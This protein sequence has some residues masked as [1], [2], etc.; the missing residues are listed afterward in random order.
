LLVSHIYAE[1]KR[2]LL[3]L[4]S[5]ERFSVSVTE[6]LD[7]PHFPRPRQKPHSYQ[8]MLGMVDLEVSKMGMT[9]VSGKLL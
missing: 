7:A 6:P 2:Y 5:F 3:G 4:K 9:E 8:W 1:Q